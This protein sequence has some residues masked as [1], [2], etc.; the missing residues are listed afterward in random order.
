MLFV[1]L[2]M[3][4][5]I[6]KHITLMGQILLWIVSAWANER[7]NSTGRPAKSNRNELLRKSSRKPQKQNEQ[8]KIISESAA[9]AAE[10]L[11]HS[12]NLTS[13][14][15]LQFVYIYSFVF[16]SSYARSLISS[17]PATSTTPP[18]PIPN[19]NKINIFLALFYVLI[20]CV[21]IL[22]FA[23]CAFAAAQISISIWRIG[24]AWFELFDAFMSI[25][26]MKNDRPDRFGSL[27]FVDRL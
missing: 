20:L 15:L 10:V 4:G 25:F 16:T 7:T 26:T 18:F 17:G 14:L 19:N 3:I 6:T 21:V 13:H 5:N 12:S 8:K 1:L 22:I 24:W 9:V 11:Q 27:L 2:Y 23:L